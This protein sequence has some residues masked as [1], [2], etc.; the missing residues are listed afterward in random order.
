M[1]RN[2]P[3]VDTVP[4]QVTFSCRYHLATRHRQSISVHK[5]S[6]HLHYL[7]LYENAAAWRPDPLSSCWIDELCL[8]RLSAKYK[9]FC[10]CDAPF[11]RFVRKTSPCDW[12]GRQ[13]QIC[14][15]RL[16]SEAHILDKQLFRAIAPKYPK[17]STSDYHTK[18]CISSRTD[19]RL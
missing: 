5:Q 3:L 16:Q 9:F 1:A 18:H 15:V 14:F 12:V 8:F 7:P 10:I 2:S 4:S 13:M 6:K 17:Y 19:L 11:G